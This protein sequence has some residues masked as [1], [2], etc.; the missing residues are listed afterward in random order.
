MTSCVGVKRYPSW[1]AKLLT[2]ALPGCADWESRIGGIV[3]PSTTTRLTALTGNAANWYRASQGPLSFPISITGLDPVLGSDLPVEPCLNELTRC[4]DQ[5]RQ[6]RV[7]GRRKGALP[8]LKP[9]LHI[10]ER[11]QIAKAGARR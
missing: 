10:G 6:Q 1:I 7:V 4:R 5:T 3:K 2:P 9:R 8:R 11:R